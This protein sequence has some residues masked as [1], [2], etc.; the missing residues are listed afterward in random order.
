MARCLQ[1]LIIRTYNIIIS[2]SKMLQRGKAVY[3]ENNCVNFEVGH[4]KEMRNLLYSINA[5]PILYEVKHCSRSRK[6]S[7][8]H[9]SN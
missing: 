7:L 5:T 6:C 2:W 8:L 1:V 9:M 4:L 3:A